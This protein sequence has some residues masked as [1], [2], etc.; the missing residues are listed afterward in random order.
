MSINLNVM[1]R[2]VLPISRHLVATEATDYNPQAVN[3]GVGCSAV[4]ADFRNT[5][6]SSAWRPPDW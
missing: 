6:D 4:T 2:S 5:R 1:R 3:S